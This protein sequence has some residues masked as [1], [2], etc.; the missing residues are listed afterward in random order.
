M[1]RLPASPDL[2]GAGTSVLRL[3]SGADRITVQP[4]ACLVTRGSSRGWGPWCLP[5]CGLW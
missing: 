1:G 4:R 3:P 2:C 5:H